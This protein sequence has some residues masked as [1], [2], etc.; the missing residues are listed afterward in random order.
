MALAAVA[1]ITIAVARNLETKS[2]G[3]EVSDLAE[4]FDGRLGIVVLEFALRGAHA[5]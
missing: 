4:E 5:A 1:A 3:A 2:H